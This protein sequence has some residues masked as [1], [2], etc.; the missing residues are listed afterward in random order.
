MENNCHV[1]TL[2][3]FDAI[4]KIHLS[5][6]YIHGM[7]KTP[8]YYARYPTVIRS[9]LT[10]LKKDY[11]VIGYKH[12]DSKHMTGYGIV[13]IPTSNKMPYTAFIMGENMYNRDKNDP[14]NQLDSGMMGGLAI[15]ENLAKIGE[16]RDILQFFMAL[17]L[18]SHLALMRFS[19]FFKK[20]NKH[21]LGRYNFLLFSVVG[22][23]GEF[24]NS[25]EELLL[26]NPVMPRMQN[27]AIVEVSM[28]EKYRLEHYAD[29]IGL[30]NAD[31]SKFVMND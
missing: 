6:H 18:K 5:Q 17:P 7:E 2:E 28:M 13:W 30:K 23:D 16:E 26:K 20:R 11:K 12:N 4:N 14:D 25:I 10:G 22:E 9:I 8:A 1:C 19:K 21:L 24:K 31:M 29:R 27:I 3:D 15:A